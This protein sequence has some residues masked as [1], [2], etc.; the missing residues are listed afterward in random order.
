MGEHLLCKQGVVG[1]NPSSSTIL[2]EGAQARVMVY[3]CLCV[4]FALF[5]KNQ[6][7]GSKVIAF[8]GNLGRDMEGDCIQSPATARLETE[9][10]LFFLCFV[11][12]GLIFGSARLW[13]QAIKCMWWMPWRSQAM[14]D[15]QACEKLRGV[16]NETLIRR[17]PNGETQPV[18]VILC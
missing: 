16:G 11:F 14:K 17:C 1:S 4:F 9:R 8:R 18:R 2:V 6:E 3:V 5:F 13:D 15:A 7:E 12:R 10:M